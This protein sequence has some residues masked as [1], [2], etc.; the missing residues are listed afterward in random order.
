MNVKV[1]EHIAA[2]GRKF[3]LHDFKD[4]R[5]AFVHPKGVLVL[6]FKA[7]QYFYDLSVNHPELI[8]K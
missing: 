2:D 8:S 1:K 6:V 5:G 3:A 4:G 7:C